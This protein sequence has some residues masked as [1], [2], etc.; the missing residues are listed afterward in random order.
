MRVLGRWC[1]RALLLAG[2]IQL[3]GCSKQQEPAA[4]AAPKTPYGRVDQARVIAAD[5]EPQNWFTTGRTFGEQ[6]FSPLEQINIDNVQQLGFAWQYDLQTERGLEATPVVVDGVLF[7]SSN[8]SKVYALDARTG[9]ELWLFDP[10]V[11]GQWARNAC[12]DVVNRGVAVWQGKVYVGTLDGRLIALDADN[13]KQLWS[14]DTFVDRERS[15]TITGAPRIAGGKVIIGNGGAEMGVRGYI[16]AYDAESGAMAWRFYTVPGDPKLPFEHPELEAAAKTWDPN[17]R[18]EAGGGGTA[19]D[20]MA[21]DPQLNLLYVGTGNASPFPQSVRSP[22]GG[23]NLYLSSILAINPDTG[24]LAWHYQTTPGESW[25]YTAVQHIILTDLQIGGTTRKVLLQAPKNGFFYVLDRAT[26]ELLSA[27]KYVE[28][29]WAS[30][31]DLKTGRPV[32]TGQGD[33]SKQAQR[34]APGPF[35]GHNWHPM[36]FSPKTGLVY[37]PTLDRTAYFAADPDYKYIP[38]RSFNT[39]RAGVVEYATQVSDGAVMTR[40]GALKAWDPV[41]QREVWR[42]DYPWFYNGGL[43]ATAGNLVFQG[44]TD[45]YLKAYAADTGKLAAEVLVGTSI[46]AAPVSYAVDGEQFISVLAGYGGAQLD[47][48]LEGSAARKYG[49]AGRIVTFKLG[50]GKVPVPSEKD[51]NANIPP[52]P[53]R[54]PADAATLQ[55]GGL[56]F[57]QHCGV[58]HVLDDAPSGYPNLLRLPQGKHAIFDEIVLRGALASR[59]MASFA[60]EISEVDA[61]AIHAFLIDKAYEARAKR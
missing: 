19:W 55:H 11:D 59:G 31:V 2:A 28:V 44:T 21:Y 7:T 35:G 56:L 40:K 47:E 48:F 49:N 12:C 1:V 9:R 42:V 60:N 27:E 29:N 36:A 51:W 14:Q 30:H 23:D 33:Y 3:A 13:G 22:K 43:L 50:G 52:L 39:G 53:E 32:P 15:Y 26:G 37:I 38:R 41:A 45:G 8:W 18:W 24:R 5:A 25:D 16:T 10:K 34:V 17:S 20:S 4:P 54:M 61:H 46:M 6:R 58:C 57:G